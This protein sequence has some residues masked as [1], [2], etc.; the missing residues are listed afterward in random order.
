LGINLLE[1]LGGGFTDTALLVFQGSNQN[2]DSSLRLSAKLG[3]GYGRIMPNIAILVLQGCSKARDHPLGVGRSDAQ[4]ANGFA[5][6]HYLRVLELLEP[7]VRRLGT[8]APDHK[9]RQ[10]NYQEALHRFVL[11][12]PSWQ[13]EGEGP[14]LAKKENFSQ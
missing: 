10:T 12:P 2:R 14:P 9:H 13:A 5:S 3:Q 1:G 6:F 4:F 7:I 8:T 11:R